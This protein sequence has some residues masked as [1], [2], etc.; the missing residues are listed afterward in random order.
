MKNVILTV[1]IIPTTSV[2]T[3]S[4]F[5]FTRTRSTFMLG[6]FFKLYLQ[7]VV[8][9]SYVSK[10]ILDLVF[11]SIVDKEGKKVTVLNSCG[12]KVFIMAS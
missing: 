4:L 6:F 1:N 10:F 5:E 12:G 11:M 3:S 2:R 8:V 9:F 7:D